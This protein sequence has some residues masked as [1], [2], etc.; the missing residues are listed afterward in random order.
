MDR[1]KKTQAEFFEEIVVDTHLPSHSVT[2]PSIGACC[3]LPIPNIQLVT[4]DTE[5]N[6]GHQPQQQYWNRNWTCF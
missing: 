1:G 2:T 5:R 6:C 4:V 3:Q